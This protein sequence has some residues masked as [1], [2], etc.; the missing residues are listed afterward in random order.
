MILGVLIPTGLYLAFAIFII[1]LLAMHK[2]HKWIAPFSLTVVTAVITAFILK[3]IIMRPR[4]LELV[5]YLPFMSI[6]DY[7]F[8]SS[9]TAF[10]FSILPLLNQELKQ[11]RYIWIGLALLVAFSRI[12][13]NAHY[14]SDVIFGALLGYAIG[15]GILKLKV[16][17]K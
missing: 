7:S 11:Y 3:L 14:F 15:Y 13:F 2:K 16:Q 10:M 4:P 1:I 12:Y 8:P 5:E 17:Q 9:H 6:I